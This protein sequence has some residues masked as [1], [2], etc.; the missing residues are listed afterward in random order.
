MVDFRTV[1]I[2]SE[3]APKGKPYPVIREVECKAC[4]RCIDACPKNVLVLSTEINE[5]GYR[6]VQY[7]GDGCTG[8]A[9]CFYACPEPNT[10]TVHKPARKT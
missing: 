1:A 7:L 6:Y 5:R 9:N 10:I 4:G 2:V 8:C 3:A